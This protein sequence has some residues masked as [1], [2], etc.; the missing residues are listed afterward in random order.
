MFYL[1]LYLY[2][3]INFIKESLNNFVQ[4]HLTCNREQSRDTKITIVGPQNGPKCH[5]Q[6]YQPRNTHKLMQTI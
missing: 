1:Y 2:L 3:Y 4:I 6:Q 5:F